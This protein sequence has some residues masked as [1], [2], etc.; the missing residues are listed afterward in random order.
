MNSTELY[1]PTTGNWTNAGNMPVELEYHT[2]SVLKDGNVLIR[3]GRLED[4]DPSDTAEL[5]NSSTETFT[6]FHSIKNPQ[7]SHKISMTLFL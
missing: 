3:C 2:A 5:Y 6:S 7:S 1:D 4:R